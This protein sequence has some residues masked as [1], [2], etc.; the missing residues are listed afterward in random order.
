MRPGAPDKTPKFVP[1]FGELSEILVVF[2]PAPFGVGVP[3]F[4]IPSEAG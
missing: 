3:S 4:S 1:F 2:E